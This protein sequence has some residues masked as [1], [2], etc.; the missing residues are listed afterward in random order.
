MPFRLT[1]KEYRKLTKTQMRAYGKAMVVKTIGEEPMI[2]RFSNFK[3]HYPKSKYF[4]V[5]NLKG[6]NYMIVVPRSKKIIR[7][8]K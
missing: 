4:T 3:L 6:T 7:K 1:N 8:K 2:F 5:L